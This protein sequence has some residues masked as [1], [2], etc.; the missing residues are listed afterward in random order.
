V[1][2]DELKSMFTTRVRRSVRRIRSTDRNG[3]SSLVEAALDLGTIE[4]NG[5]SLPIAELELELVEGS[6]EALYALA[7]ELDALSSLRVETRSKS[8]R[9]YALATGAAPA[10]HKAEAPALSSDAPVDE[11]LQTILRNCVEH[12]CANEAA[13]CDGSDPEGVHQMRVAIRRLRSAFS[14][15]GRLIDPAERARLSGGAKTI[16]NGLGPARDWDV[17]LVELLAPVAAARPHDTALARLRAAAET[18]RAR[19]YVHTRAAIVAPSYTRYMLELRRWIEAR[20]WRER[21]SARGVAWLDRPLIDFAAHRLGKRHRKALERGR[22]F[23]ELSPEQRHRARIALKKLR[24][25]TEFFEALFPRKRTKPYL[26]ALKDLQDDVGHF[27]DVA[28]AEKLIGSLI[29]QAAG[30][31]DLRVAAGLV[32]G[33]HARGVA[34]IEPTVVRAWKEFAGRE[35]FWR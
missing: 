23:A 13:A 22:D 16:V 26:A 5:S 15:F 1:S 30:G 14:V 4:C 18:A 35:P 34:D 19:G 29:Q 12:W 31:A 11:A 27:N 10:W 28:V 9:G 2:P 20:G 24:Y 7:L 6:P 21:A 25:A 3:G 17:F 32:L 33:W 8:A